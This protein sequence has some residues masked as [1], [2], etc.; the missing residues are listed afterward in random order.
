MISRTRQSL[1]A[2]QFFFFFGARSRLRC[3]NELGGFHSS[4][5]L[6]L[7]SFAIAKPLKLIAAHPRL[8]AAST[9]SRSPGPP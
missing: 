5:D 4:S 2:E 6:Q 3:Q 8:Y 1:C 9:D 7:R